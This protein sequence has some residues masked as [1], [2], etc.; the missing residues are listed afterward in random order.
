M[1][2]ITNKAI[3]RQMHQHDLNDIFSKRS[4][5]GDKIFFRCKLQNWRE[6]NK[7]PSLICCDTN[8]PKTLVKMDSDLDGLSISPMSSRSS[9]PEA[10]SSLPKAIAMPLLT[11]ISKPVRHNSPQTS[12]PSPSIQAPQSH[13]TPETKP[14]L[15]PLLPPA[16]PVPYSPMPIVPNSD[17]TESSRTFDDSFD[18]EAELKRSFQGQKILENYRKFNILGKSDQ[19]NLTRIV[20]NYHL[21]TK[22][23]LSAQIYM[24]YVSKI[25]Q[26]FPSECKETYYMPANYK[27]RK[28]PR[29]KLYD[30]FNNMKRQMRAA[31]EDSIV[32][33]IRSSYGSYQTQTPIFENLTD[34]I[35]FQLE[36][37]E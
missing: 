15:T 29:G 2:G 16:K 8:K 10:S 11:P 21:M 37:P 23:P 32:Q 24:F 17:F 31:D 25:Q 19:N 20:A 34:S 9:S 3:L 26:L 35:R 30:R 14:S 22:M 4:Q 5:I 33:S 12:Q 36:Y 6:E 28:P 18:L 1:C 27:M 7:H 13:T